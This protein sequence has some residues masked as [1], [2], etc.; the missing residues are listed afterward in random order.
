ME[1]LLFLGVPILKHITVEPSGVKGTK[2]CSN[3]PGHMMAIL[4]NNR[5]SLEIFFSGTNRLIALKLDRWRQ[6]HA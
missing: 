2:I 3:G 4:V 6:V 5:K 1:N